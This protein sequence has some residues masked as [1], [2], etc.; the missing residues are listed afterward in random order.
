LSVRTPES[1]AYSRKEDFIPEQEDHSSVQ[2][3][4]LQKTTVILLPEKG[5]FSCIE[6]GYL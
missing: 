2:L 1:L 6:V 4:G 5:L 3:N